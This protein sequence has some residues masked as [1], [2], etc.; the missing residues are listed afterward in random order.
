MGFKVAIDGPAGAGK[1]TVAKA[2]AEAFSFIYVDTGAM[3]RAIG[4]Y[5][6]RQGTD[7]MDEEAV[8]E[9]LPEIDV[10]I[11]YEDG[12]QQVFLNG[13][14]VSALIRTQ[15]VGDAASKTSAYREVRAKLLSLQRGLAEKADVLMD[16]R[17]IGTEVLPDAEL[18]IYLTADTRVRA[19][20]RY[21]ELTGRGQECSLDEIEEEI[22]ER[23]YRDMHREVAPLRKAEDAVVLDTSFLDIRESV[24][25]VAALIRERKGNDGNNCIG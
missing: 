2:A 6:L 24:E 15:E 25:A 21:H 13:E 14:N 3:Y 8:A 4:L 9:K 1:S 19:E 23:D 22:K 7:L 11:A 12:T 17:D 16:G 5:L 20:R 18:K 10:T